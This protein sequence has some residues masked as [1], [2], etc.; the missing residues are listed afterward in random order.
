MGNEIFTSKNL[1][2]GG[3]V[4]CVGIFNYDLQYTKHSIIKIK[5]EN[6]QKTPHIDACVHF[7]MNFPIVSMK[8]SL[9]F[10]R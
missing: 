9:P 1:G 10:L 5:E 4:S 8:M 2:G 6:K 3:I 7:F